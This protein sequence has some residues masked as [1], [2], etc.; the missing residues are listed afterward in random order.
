MPGTPDSTPHGTPRSQSP[1]TV[2]AFDFGLRRIGVAIGQDVTGSASPL[3]TLIQGPSGPDWDEIGTVIAE[4]QPTRLVV[5]MPSHA[6]GSPSEIAARVRGFMAGLER[7]GLPVSSVDERY[8]SLE[9]GELLKAARA[10]G[11]RGRIGRE[12]I[13]SAA[14]VLIAE[15]WLKQNRRSHG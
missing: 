10:A 6:D 11:T 8:S 5:G 14:A 12:M 4:W 3:R 2:L 15:R 7:F 9:G 13:D 1:Q